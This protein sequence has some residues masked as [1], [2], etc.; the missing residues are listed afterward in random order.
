MAKT[1]KEASPVPTEAVTQKRAPRIMI[2][3]VSPQIDGGLFPIKRIAGERVVVRANVF[4]DGH[5]EVRADLLYRS[6]DEHD[7]HETPMKA[8]GNDAWIGSFAVTEEKEYLYTIRGYVCEFSSWCHDL[9]K[10]VD[11]KRDVTIDLQIGSALLKDAATRAKGNDQKKLLTWAEDLLKTDHTSAVKLALS[12]ELYRFMD[13]HLDLE[14][15]VIYAQ[16]L[17]VDVERPRAGFSSWYEFFPRSWGTKPGVHGTFKEAARILPEISRMGFDIVYLPPIHPIGTA[18]RKGKNNAT[19]CAKD[20]P[21]SPWAVGSKDGGHKAVNPQLGTLADLN[22]F[23]KKANENNLEVALDIAFQCSPDHPY[24][25]EHPSWFKWR[26]DGTV[27]YAENPPKKYEDIVPFNFET[28]DQA[29]LWEELKSVFIFWAK[30]GVRVFRVDNPHTKP[31][32][33]WDWTIKEVRKE[34]PDV[35]FLA[36]AFTR[37][38]IMY[39]LAKGGVTHSYTYFTWRNSKKE[40]EEYLTELSRSEAAEFFRPNFWP[41]TPD[42]LADHLQHGERSAFVM[43]AVLAATLSSNYGVYGPAFELCENKPFPGKEEYTDSEKYEVKIW[44][45]DRPGNIKDVLTKLNKIRRENPAL[46]MTRNIRFCKINNEQIF[47]YYKATADFSNIILVLVNL[48]PRHPQ[49]GMLELPLHELGITQNHPYAAE[50]L[51]TGEKFTWNGEKNFVEL[52]PAKGG[53]HIIRLTRT[54]Q[55]EPTLDYFL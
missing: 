22:D 14:K 24:L 3:K 12:A 30:Q 42:I 49:S 17:K 29:A 1:K 36:E 31:F 19:T 16:E 9:K 40:F 7:W 51:Y 52:N 46:Q 55:L 38:N 54:L 11:A 25:K 33:F 6:K 8:L 2:E 5:D 18:F 41:N 28:M 15:S 53:A 44:D 39:R 48:D 26:P 27:Q 35:I 34:F 50:D 10:R 47:A 20:D 32:L 23:V 37:P 45:W 13:E 43:R 4:A 21:G